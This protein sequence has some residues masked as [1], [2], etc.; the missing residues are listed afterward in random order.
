MQYFQ[1]NPM[2]RSDNYHLKQL[3]SYQYDEAVELVRVILEETPEAVD[4]FNT[5]K[6]MIEYICEA[7]ALNY[8]FHPESKFD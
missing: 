4:V 7:I 6:E 5:R 3:E 8:V 2:G 1:I